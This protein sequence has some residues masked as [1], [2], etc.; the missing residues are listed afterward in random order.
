VLKRF[1]R[2]KIPVSAIKIGMYILELDRPWIETSFL[3][4][5]FEVL[6]DEDVTKL[7]KHCEY[8]FIDTEQGLD[9]DNSDGDNLGP[10]HI[11]LASQESEADTSRRLEQEMKGHRGIFGFTTSQ[12]P[13]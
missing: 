1:M 3:F 13:G 4:Q 2:K 8:V 6:D 5:G 9:I 7:N 11:D 12:V 10:W